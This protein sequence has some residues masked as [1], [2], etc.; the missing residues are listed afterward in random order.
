MNTFLK[1]LEQMAKGVRQIDIGDMAA[2]PNVGAR[3]Q[4]VQRLLEDATNAATKADDWGWKGGKPGEL[5]GGEY[6]RELRAAKEKADAAR[7]RAEMR[8]VSDDQFANEYHRLVD[9]KMYPSRIKAETQLYADGGGYEATLADRWGEIFTDS[10]MQDFE[11][12]ERADIPRSYTGKIL[13]ALRRELRSAYTTVDPDRAQQ[14]SDLMRSLSP[15]ERETFV[16]LL[17]EWQDSLE[18]LAELARTI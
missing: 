3:M 5:T 10:I 8:G 6:M 14:V 9:E 17:P 2:R 11:T 1:A 15:D 16:S 12:L 7:S 4:A 13:P 18:E